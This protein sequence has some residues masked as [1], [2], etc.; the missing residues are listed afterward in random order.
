[1][2]VIQF[3]KRNGSIATMLGEVFVKLADFSEQFAALSDGRGGQNDEAV[4][5]V[6]SAFERE[7]SGHEA[8]SHLPAATAND[9]GGLLLQEP[10]L[11]VV[12]F[13]NAGVAREL[14]G[15]KRAGKGASEAHDGGGGY[16][17]GGGGAGAGSA[18]M[19]CAGGSHAAL[20]APA[21]A[22]LSTA[23]RAADTSRSASGCRLSAAASASRKRT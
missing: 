6:H 9:A 5:F 17:M 15:I 4:R 11:P 14:R 22:A 13:G 20:L 7:Q 8:F 21:T 2:A 10:Q 23:M 12:Q 19:T 1:M 3:Q 16:L 18:S